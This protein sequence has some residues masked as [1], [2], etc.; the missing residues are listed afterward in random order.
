MKSALLLLNR[1]FKPRHE[2]FDECA[3][4]QTS[5]LAYSIK[6]AEVVLS[7]FYGYNDIADK[8]VLDYGCGRGGKTIFYAT[9][10]AK[11]VIGFDVN[12]DY[13]LAD[14]YAKKNNLPVEFRSLNAF[15]GIDLEDSGVDV[16][17]SSSVLEHIIDFDQAMGELRRVLKPGGLFLNRWHPFR[18]RNGAHLQ[19]ALGIPFAHLLFREKEVMGTYCQELLRAHGT[20]PDFFKRLDPDTQMYNNRH[21]TLNFYTV[22]AMR[23]KIESLGFR[24]LS[25]RFLI[26]KKEINYI[27]IIP[28][29]LIDYFIDYEVQVWRNNSD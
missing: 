22:R 3:K 1:I 19:E 4:A 7:Q 25:R 5:A 10:N 16:I 9:K 27:R 26:D 21:C 12:P 14:E 20:L 11:K 29:C 18:S 6:S 8:V 24:L 17:I 15:R 23:K 2:Y 28:E 13:A